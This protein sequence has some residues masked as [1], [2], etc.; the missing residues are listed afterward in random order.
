[1][2]AD[3]LAAWRLD[4]HGNPVGNP[5]RFAYD[6]TG[7]ADHRDA[8][9]ATP[10]P[11]CCT[12]PSPA[13]LPRSRSKTWTSR[14]RR[15]ARNTAAQAVPPADLRHAHRQAPR[16]ADLDG[17]RDRHRDHRRRPGL[18]LQLGS[19]ALAEAPDQRRAR[20]PATMQ[21]ASRS[22]DAPRA[23]DPATDGTAP[24]RPERSS[25]HRS[26]Q[27][28]PDAP[29]VREPAPASPDHGHDPCRRT[30]RERGRPGRP[31]PFGMSTVTRYGY[32]T[33]SCSLMRNGSS[34]RA[35]RS[36]GSASRGPHPWPEVGARRLGR[37]ASVGACVR[38]P[39]GV[40]RRAL[41]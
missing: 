6:L 35:S 27:A 1:M 8:Q 36:A 26:V 32:K 22:D 16:P 10:S 39:P 19:P 38:R 41:P 23:P 13:A 4:V 18:H 29:G 37:R 24:Q 15:P 40:E 34:T 11:G 7:T 25:G 14:R 9:C 33:H 20:P 12:G 5:R 3:H 17:R 21:R 30:R 31:T 28:R 2:N